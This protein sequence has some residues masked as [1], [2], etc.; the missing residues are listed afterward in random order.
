MRNSIA[1]KAVTAALS[2]MLVLAPVAPAFADQFYPTYDSVPVVQTF[3]T[4][5]WDY[6]P[7]DTGFGYYN[8]YDYYYRGRNEGVYAEFD[9]LAGEDRFD[10]MRRIL[11]ETY[12]N[13]TYPTVIVASGKNFPDALTANGLAG[14][15][16]A[17]SVDVR[18]PIILTDNN[19]LSKEARDK[20]IDFRAENIYIMGGEKAISETVKKE[21]EN[22]RPSA[23][24]GR[25]AGA[26]R[27]ATSVEGLKRF[28]NTPWMRSGNHSIIIATGKTYA[29]ALSISPVAKQLGMPIILTDNNGLLTE[30]AVKAI[31]ELRYY[32]N[33]IYIVGGTDA[34]SDSVRDQL[35]RNNYT[36]HRL[37]G[38]D[39][40]DTSVAIA[41]YAYDNFG[42]GFSDVNIAT[43]KNFPDALAGG[44]LS[45]ENNSV[46]LLVDDGHTSK[47]ESLLAWAATNDLFSR[48]GNYIKPGFILGGGNAV[49]S[50]TEQTLEDVIEMFSDNYWNYNDYRVVYYP[51]GSVYIEDMLGNGIYIDKYNN[52][53]FYDYKHNVITLG[54][55]NDNTFAIWFENGKFNI[56]LFENWFNDA[57]NSDWFDDMINYINNNPVIPAPIDE[58]ID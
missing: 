26:D 36:Y 46:M 55:I 19:H 25:I 9:R 50:K 8:N 1:Q 22:A 53:T 31:N 5:N 23:W 11:N 17:I 43:G 34:V 48:D 49:S 35:G 2:S 38:I 32:I 37:G 54:N 58:S 56:T 16:E 24:V 28:A 27:Q 44:Q 40:Y 6:S 51:D 29:D 33:D 3:P 15:L 39:R 30:D 21:I 14:M 7:F 41:D 4:L 20:L 18:V 12:G 45:A 42:F 57:W 10:T 13:G 52:V 47:A